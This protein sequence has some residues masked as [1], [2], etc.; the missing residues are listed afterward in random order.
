MVYFTSDLHYGD[1]R[2]HTQLRRSKTLSI[3]DDQI[4]NLIIDNWNKKVTNYDTVFVLGDIT[5][6]GLGFLKLLKGRKILIRGNH[7]TSYTDDE[8]LEYFDGVYDT[9]ILKDMF[10]EPVFLCHK[11]ED[12]RDDMITLN[13]HV[14]DVWKYYDN[15]INVG[16]EC[17]G[18]APV[19]K[20]VLEEAIDTLKYLDVTNYK[21]MD[22]YGVII[23]I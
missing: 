11:P 2:P 10:S 23:V 8:L 19:S 3:P 17:W 4:D 16:L 7:D 5:F 18:M 21:I 12:A 1:H 22:D 13:G 14:H 20:D 15:K 9:L 6:K